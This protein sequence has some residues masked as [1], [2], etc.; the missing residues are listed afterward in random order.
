MY[1][2]LHQQGL[3]GFANYGY[4]SSTEVDSEFAWVQNFIS[5]YQYGVSKD[6]DY[7]RAVRAF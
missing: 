7:V 1:I 4:W 3:G 6:Y 5:G 2:N